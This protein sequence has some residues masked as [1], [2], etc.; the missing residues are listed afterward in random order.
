MSAIDKENSAAAFSSHFG[1]ATLNSK[2]KSSMRKFGEP[3]PIKSHLSNKNLVE[4]PLT[5][6]K[7]RALGDLLNTAARSSTY[8]TPLAPSKSLIQTKPLFKDR[9]QPS[10]S[11]NSVCTSS[12]T[13]G[14]ELNWDDLPPV[15]QRVPLQIDDFTD[16]FPNGKLSEMSIMP[17]KNSNKKARFLAPLPFEP[18]AI[19]EDR[20]HP[21]LLPQISLVSSKKERKREKKLEKVAEKK[22]D[23]DLLLRMLCNVNEQIEMTHLPEII[24][25]DEE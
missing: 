17:A 20:F 5:G 23:E 22:R 12:S 18:I 24:D 10:T 3:T 21:N 2:S 25:T 9:E 7:R 6:N 13:N 16:M 15:E 14:S 1:S 19:S 4:T 11:S 8:A